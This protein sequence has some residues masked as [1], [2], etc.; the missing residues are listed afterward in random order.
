MSLTDGLIGHTG[1][2][3]SHLMRRLDPADCFNSTSIASIRGRRFGTLVISGLP[4]AK[5]LANRDPAADYRNMMTLYE[6]LTHVE[7]ERVIVISTVDVYPFARS[8]DEE[9]V[10][11][12]DLCQPYGKHRLLFERLIAARFPT[13]IM[14][15]PALFGRGLKKNVVFDFLNRHHLDRIDGRG[16][17]QFYDLARLPGDVDR[18]LA[19]GIATLNVTS[20]PLAVAAVAEICLGEPFV[21]DLTSPVANY[22][23]RSRHATAFGGADGYLYDESI[24]VADLRRFVAGY[25][26]S[27]P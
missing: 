14:R 19:S 6:H 7:A 4:A 27:P 23:V 18:F 26:R 25:E 5:W 17:F 1:L 9:T 22:D 21:N 13:Q 2:V 24:V 11:D 15:L 16:R 3:G 10:I 20:A 8:V 12:V